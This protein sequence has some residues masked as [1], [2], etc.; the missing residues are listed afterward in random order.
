MQRQNSKSKPTLVFAA[1]GV[2]AAAVGWYI[3]KAAASASQ[4]QSDPQSVASA[5]QSA[6]P[7][8]PAPAAGD[9]T[10]LRAQT[11]GERSSAPRLPA[12]IQPVSRPVTK[13]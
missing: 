10:E 2:L 1:V 6:A 12:V 4:P 8:Q 3:F 11:P 13:V 7:T 9:D 5:E